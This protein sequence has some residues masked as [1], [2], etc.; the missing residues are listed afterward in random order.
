[1]T[2][3][4]ASPASS[5]FERELSEYLACLRIPKEHHD[6]AA[7]LCR[8]HD[9]S[10]ARAHLIVSRPGR[11]A[12]RACS[13]HA[14]GHTVAARTDDAADQH[15]KFLAVIPIHML[16]PMVLTRL[17]LQGQSLP[18][19]VIWQCEDCWA[20]SASRIVLLKR[21]W[22]LSS[23]RSVPSVK[24]GCGSSVRAWHR[25]LGCEVR[26]STSAWKVPR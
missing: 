9:F 26:G 12:G 23:H 18:H 4:E 7:Q 2:Q 22:S 6:H 8:E 13:T 17:A 16:L 25:D 19:M 10:A 15:V 24:T 3:T 21:P 20:R 1:M 11:H 14:D 5:T